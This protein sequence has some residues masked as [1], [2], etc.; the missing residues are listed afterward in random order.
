MKYLVLTW[1]LLGCTA[2]CARW[3]PPAPTLPVQK[4]DTWDCGGV[5]FESEVEPLRVEVNGELVTCRRVLLPVWG[6]R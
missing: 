2:D 5:Q 4:L 3:P 1:L 6:V